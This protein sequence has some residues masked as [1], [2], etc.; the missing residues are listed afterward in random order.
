MTAFHPTKPATWALP[1]L[2]A[3]GLAAAQDAG[4]AATQAAM[5]AISRLAQL[6]GTAL[7]CQDT[8]A[9]RRAKQLMLAHAPKT[10]RYGQAFED[11]TQAAF[12]ATTAGQAACPDTADLARR[13]DGAAR[14][15][16]AVLPAVL[17][18]HGAR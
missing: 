18:A 4:D 12:L 3:A 11:G 2:L 1:L 8:T 5:Q 10:A 7:A 13:L 17:A 6:N 9:A 15:L 14:E 16:Q